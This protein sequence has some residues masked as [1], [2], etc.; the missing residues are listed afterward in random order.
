VTSKGQILTASAKKNSDLFWALK[1]GG[2]NFGIVTK[3][4]LAAYKT[5]KVS[6][7]LQYRVGNASVK[8][9]LTAAVNYALHH[10]KEDIGSGGIFSSLNIP[11]ASPSNGVT[12]PILLLR[13]EGATIGDVSKSPKVFRNVT[14]VPGILSDSRNISSLAEYFRPQ[15]STLQ[16]GR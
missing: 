5:P 9:Y 6:T 12:S 2:N 4:T 10:E 16:A 8:A 3:L 11:T 13:F 1:G 14:K 7:S 15:P